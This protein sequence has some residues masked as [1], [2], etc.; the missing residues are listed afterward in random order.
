M[1]P[2]ARPVTAIAATSISRLLH[3]GMKANTT[4]MM[5]VDA[6]RD[7]KEEQSLEGIYGHHSIYSKGLV[8]VTGGD[9]LAASI[10]SSNIMLH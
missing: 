6:A 9:T 10:M 7:D 8:S 5:N 1:M 2:I 4:E 3:S